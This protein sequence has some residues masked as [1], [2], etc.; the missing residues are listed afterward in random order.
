[1]CA[2]NMSLKHLTQQIVYL[3]INIKRRRGIEV[4]RDVG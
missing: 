4:Y 2:C 1:M 3:N